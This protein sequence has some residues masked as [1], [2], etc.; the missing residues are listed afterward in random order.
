MKNSLRRICMRIGIVLFIVTGFFTLNNVHITEAHSSLVEQ[1]PA[2][3]EVTKKAPKTL[4]LEFNEP[5]EKDLSRVIIYDWNAKPVFAGKPVGNVPRAPVL[6]YEIP[7]LAEGTYT[8]K[9]SVVSLD[10]H[11]VEG[12][13]SFSVG[14]ETVN[15]VSSVSSSENTPAWLIAARTA[16]QGL[17]ILSAGVYLFAICASKRGF[18]ELAVLVGKRYFVLPLLLLI[19]LAELGAYIYT[20]PPGLPGLLIDGGWKII[21]EFPFILMILAQIF[22]LLFLLIPGML[23]GW[24]AAL[25]LIL[26]MIPAFGGHALGT[27]LPW[28]GLM[29]RIL[30]QLSI[31]IWLGALL[32]VVLLL[33][34]VRAKELDW[35]G[36]RPFFFK[37]VASASAAVVLSGIGMA[38]LQMGIGQI[39]SNW[40]TWSTL[41][42]IKVVGTLFM[43]LL[44]LYQ[45]LKWRKQGKFETGRLVRLEWMIGLV[46]IFFGV[47]M[48]QI[49]YP[50]KVHEYDE[51]LTAGNKRIQLHVDDLHTGN[52]NMEIQVPK[53]DGEEPEKVIVELY[54]PAHGMYEGPIQAERKDGNQYEAK[55]PLSM[56]GKWQVFIEAKY[57]NEKREWDTKFKVAGTSGN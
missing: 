17:L 14:Q 57:K 51:T 10:G 30:H 39:F 48:S 53:L 32:Y 15:G 33:W 18:P 22:V 8:V 1:S 25:W 28:F 24:Y 13:Y 40:M 45:T 3:D 37:A 5:I 54:M 19:S 29:L 34:K 16:G 27:D 9:W 31:T 23:S 44:A 56:S 6:R 20:L 12:S 7:K 47:W 21:R 38:W 55:L 46:I 35:I 2:I 4:K 41:L 11:P 26:A 36:F 42:V 52:P 50:V 49:A 43:L